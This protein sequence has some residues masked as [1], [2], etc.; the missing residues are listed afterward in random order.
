MDYSTT[1]LS[2]HTDM[3]TSYVVEDYPYGFNLRTTIRYWVETK[4]R[5]GQR[6]VS[7]TMNPKTGRWNKTKPGIYMPVIML[8]LDNDNG[9]VINQGVGTYAEDEEIEEFA[10]WGTGHLDEWQEGA[11]DYLRAVNRAQKRVTI[12]APICQPGCT[13]N[14]QTME[15]QAALMRG[16]IREELRT[17]KE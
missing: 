2:G 3:E 13:E 15:E 7:Q 6:V 8:A 14:H 16:V 1:P 9:H 12:T 10:L 11:L 4:K 17:G 5:F